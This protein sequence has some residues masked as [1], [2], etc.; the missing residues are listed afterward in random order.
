MPVSPLV[1][2]KGDP[3]RRAMFSKNSKKILEKKKE[4]RKGKIGVKASV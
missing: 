4:T 1:K 3:R 2:K